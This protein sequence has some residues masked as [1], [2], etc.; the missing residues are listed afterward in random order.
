MSAIDRSRRDL[1]PLFQEFA[2]SWEQEV[3][4]GTIMKK[5]EV[6]KKF[7]KKNIEKWNAIHQ[8]LVDELT[9]K[10]GECRKDE[11]IKKVE[12][13]WN[14]FLTCWAGVEMV[15]DRQEKKVILAKFCNTSKELISLFKKQIID[16]SEIV[17]EH[18]PLVRSNQ[19]YP[20]NPESASRLR[21]LE[22][23]LQDGARTSCGG[24]QIS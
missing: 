13:K 19:M 20:A 16:Q 10:M 9:K 6:V 24:C 4:E 2:D 11:G 3:L 1:V 15:K 12:K 7:S 8:N 17:S 18:F 23:P 21:E 22:N 14:E 5:G